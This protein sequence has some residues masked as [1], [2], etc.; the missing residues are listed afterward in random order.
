MIAGS[1]KREYSIEWDDLGYCG[2]RAF[3]IYWNSLGL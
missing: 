1:E 3:I 2:K